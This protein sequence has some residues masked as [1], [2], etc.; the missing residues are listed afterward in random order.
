MIQSGIGD[1]P[2]TNLMEY[3]NGTRPDTNDSDSDAVTFNTLL[4][5]GQ[6][7]SH[8]RDWNLS[9]G[10]E[11]FK[12]GTNPM[13]NDTDGICYQIGMNTKRAGMNRT[14]ISHPD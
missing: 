8:D 12:Y 6:V 4:S 11:V 10:R 7:V 1:L 9:D 5:S 13:D 14:T 2:F 3:L